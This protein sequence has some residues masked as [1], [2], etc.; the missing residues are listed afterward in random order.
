M[1][2]T[3]RL[4]QAQALATAAAKPAPS[5]TLLSRAMAGSPRGEFV[6][7]P[8]LGRAWIELAGETTVNE[9]ES[10]VFAEMRKLDLPAVTINAFTYDGH[11]TARTLAWAVRNP[12][13]IAERFGSLEEWLALDIDVISACGLVYADVRERL[14]PIGLPTITREEVDDIRLSI[15]KK[16]PIRLRSYGVAKLSLYLLT[17]GDQP[18]SSP[19]PPSSSGE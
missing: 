2:T 3:S 15:E 8:L 6:T 1:A 4:A 5:P 14:N 13:N 18:A 17:G 12:D 11:R 16:N 19:T 9:I 10:A 7:L